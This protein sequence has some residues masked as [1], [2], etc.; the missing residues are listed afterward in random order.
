M[1]LYAACRRPEDGRRHGS[2][3]WKT[4]GAVGRHHTVVLRA[5]RVVNSLE[6][7]HQRIA[8]ELDDV[9]AVAVDQVDQRREERGQ[10]LR[11]QLRPV[12]PLCE[13]LRELREAGGVR[14]DDGPRALVDDDAA[15]LQAA[16]VPSLLQHPRDKRQGA[17]KRAPVPLPEPGEDVV[18]E[19]VG[20]AAWLLHAARPRGRRGRGVGARDEG[21]IGG[22]HAMSRV[23]MLGGL[24]IGSRAGG[25]GLVACEAAA[26]VLLQGGHRRPRRSRNGE[27]THQEAVWPGPSSPARDKLA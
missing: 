14:E 12:A 2:Q 23:P 1:D 17:L 20:E 21:A 15:V 5:L 27:R 6:V 16:L 9:A 18:V 7:D 10:A 26:Q 4:I 8:A 25:L 22:V 24:L 19:G 11:Q 3:V 13:P